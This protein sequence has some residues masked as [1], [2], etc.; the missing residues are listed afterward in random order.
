MDEDPGG[1]A[2]ATSRRIVALAC[3]VRPSRSR[4]VGSRGAGVAVGDGEGAGPAPVASNVQTAWVQLNQTW[5][6]HTHEYEA[7]RL[8]PRTP[9]AVSPRLEIVT[10]SAGQE[11]S[12]G[13]RARTISVNLSGRGSAGARAACRR[14]PQPPPAA[15]TAAATATATAAVFRHGRA[16]PAIRRTSSVDPEQLGVGIL[17]RGTTSSVSRRRSSPRPCPRRPR[18][19]RARRPPESRIGDRKRRSRPGY[20][21]RS[22]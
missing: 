15:T 22:R 10:C 6:V 2:E 9:R 11:R 18:R 20:P 7:C 13:A 8:H 5:Y 16:R 1:P 17:V 3:A 19:R 4:H 12:K 21:R 14:C